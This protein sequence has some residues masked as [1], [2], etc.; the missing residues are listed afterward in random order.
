MFFDRYPY[1]DAHELNLDWIISTVKELGARMNDFEAV[2][3]I[4]YEGEWNITKQYAA[5]SLVL[6]NELSY[7]ALKPVPAGIPISNADYWQFIGSAAVDTEARAMISTLNTRV[8]GISSDLI[9]TQASLSQAV[10]DIRSAE[11]DISTLRYDTDALNAELDSEASARESADTVINARIDN[12]VALPEGSTQGDAELMDIRVGANG[13]TYSSAGD[14]VRDQFDLANGSIRTLAPSFILDRC[15]QGAINVSTGAEITSTTRLRSRWFSIE[16]TSKIYKVKF[17]TGYS[18]M[19]FIYDENKDYIGVLKPDGTYGH[20]ASWTNEIL[21]NG[22][23]GYSKIVFRKDDDST[24]DLDS[25]D[26]AVYYGFVKAGDELLDNLAYMADSISNSGYVCYD[27]FGLDDL[28]PGAVNSTGDIIVQS[29]YSNT[30]LHTSRF[31]KIIE[32]SEV[33]R[34]D[35][36]LID[37]SYNTYVYVVFYDSDYEFIS[38][39]GGQKAYSIIAEIPS[40]AAYYR[41][42]YTQITVS[43]NFNNVIS[44]SGGQG[45]VNN[46]GKSPRNKWYVLGDSIS[47]GYFSMTE[48]E[49]AEKGYTLI[50]KPSDYGYPVYGVGSAYLPDLSHNYWGYANKW[51]LHRDLQP[52]AT[53]GQGYFR[54]AGST[55]KNGVKVVQDLDVSDAGL[56]TVAWGFNDWHYD[57]TRGNHDLIDESVPYPTEGYDITQITTVNQAIWY[58]LGEL[59]RKAPNAK[60]V[61]QTPMNGW[62]YGGDWNSNWGIGYSMTHAG[63]LKDIHDDIVYWADYYGLEILD[64]T[65]NNSIVNRRNI[66]DVLIDGSHPSDPAHMQLGR[67]VGIALKYC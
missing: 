50:Y 10:S 51:F 2:N 56:I 7:I 23:T 49:A 64:M 5:W 44:V 43:G 55:S 28:E 29:A 60:I 38:R 42:T 4:K 11:S 52:N 30:S 8:N 58:C 20:A 41:V 26:K 45:I 1:S 27:S 24:I 36:D 34:S 35:I 12:I 46:S 6:D 47:A 9:E 48:A 13:R 57:Q 66:K 16:E 39:D 31:I 61:V 53:P 17:A 14:A 33:I 54:T 15:Q 21:M 19:A 3:K 25:S 63:T 18:G 67:I 62:L 37:K 32:G 65:F 59:I 40:N 22:Q